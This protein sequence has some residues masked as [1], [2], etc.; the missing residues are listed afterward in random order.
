MNELLQMV[1]S[2]PS[3]LG[4]MTEKT[5]LDASSIGGVVSKLAPVFMQKAKENFTSDADSSNL[6]NIIKQTDLDELAQKPEVLEDTSFGNKILSELTGSKEQSKSLA[7]QV[8]GLA[9]V[10]ASSVT[11]LLPM[12]APLVMGMLNKQTKQAN[13]QDTN[14]MTSM[15]TSFIDQDGDGSITDDLMGMAK[16]FF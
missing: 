14:S 13:V 7:S 11:K 10:D 16:K 12:V 3:V 15:L 5:G 9:G 4:K 6:V 8:S 1:L 2:N